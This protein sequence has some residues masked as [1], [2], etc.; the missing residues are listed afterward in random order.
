M[1]NTISGENA[2]LKM[3]PT[4]IRAMPNGE[5]TGEFLALDLGGSHFRVLF[6]KLNGR[7]AE[8]NGKIY[9]VLEELR[10]G[11]GTT[12]RTSASYF[13]LVITGLM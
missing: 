2:V 3:L 8:M 12:V 13:A 9:H 11:S 1:P 4:Y 5:E 6:I 7:E 10:K